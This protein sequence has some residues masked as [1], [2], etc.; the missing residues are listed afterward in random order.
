MAKKNVQALIAQ[1]A[2]HDD[3]GQFRFIKKD[4]GEI[5]FAIP[6]VC[7]TLDLKNPAMV[8]RRL[9]ENE[10]AKFNLGQ[11]RENE[12]H[13]FNLGYS[14]KPGNPNIW[15]ANEPGLYR[16]IFMSKKPEAKKFQ[17]WVYH[18][19]LP[20]IRKTGSYALPKKRIFETNQNID[21]FEEFDNGE[22]EIIS[23]NNATIEYDENGKVVAIYDE[24]S[25]A[26]V[27]YD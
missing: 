6:D 7:K 4:N 26:V 24:N 20:S 10:K 3:F 9:G 15:F 11:S 23:I 25:K 17:D 21:L 2:T 5:W 19:V 18:E 27:I 13:K 22:Y 12:Y 1:V 16:L 14:R 8:A